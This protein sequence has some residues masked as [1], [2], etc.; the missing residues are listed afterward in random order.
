MTNFASAGRSLCTALLLGLLCMSA[1]AQTMTEAERQARLKE[2]RATIEQ[3]KVELNKVKS[4]RQDLM[5]DLQTS[6]TQIGELSRKVQELRKQLDDKQSHLQKLSS[7]KEELLTA[8]KQQQGSVARH[9]DAAYRLGQQSSLKMLLNQQDPSLL[10][11]NLHY[12][13]YFTQ[14]QAD[15]VQR[16]TGTIARI[17]ELEPAIAAEAQAISRSHS[18]LRVKRDQLQA[19]QQERKRTLAK[20][21]RTIADTD[22]RLKSA[23]EDRHHLEKLLREVVRITGNMQMPASNQPF[24]KLKGQLPWPTSGKVLRTFGSPRV[25]NKVR[26]QGVLIGAPE[27]HPVHA[28]HQGRVVFA[29][30]LRG[31][32]LLLIIDHGSGFMS[33][34]AHNQ[35]L[36][37]NLG[38]WVNAGEQVASVGLSGGQSNSALY[39]ELRYKGEPTDPH[40]WL[41]KA[42]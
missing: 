7:E 27:G 41:R 8:K 39:F 13:R 17:E 38:D 15:E 2:L 30:Y 29:D 23:D 36:F 11:R 37:K 4:D 26:W 42:A 25:A 33:L 40:P 1:S 35:S 22:A 18:D 28:V 31:Q 19:S 20:L 12:Y 21:E 16:Y 5:G 3:L 14:A 6:E 34:Y 9:L 10:A 32:G 24:S